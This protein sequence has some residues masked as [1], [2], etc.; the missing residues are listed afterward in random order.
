M[1]CTHTHTQTLIPLITIGSS[2]SE[3]AN[4]PDWQG[5]LLKWSGPDHLAKV[6]FNEPLRHNLFRTKLFLWLMIVTKYYVCVSGSVLWLLY[7]FVFVSTP[8]CRNGAGR[9]VYRFI[10]LSS[11]GSLVLSGMCFAVDHFY[12][13]FVTSTPFR[14]LAGSVYFYCWLLSS[15]PFRGLA[16]S[17]M[18]LDCWMWSSADRGVAG[19]IYIWRLLLFDLC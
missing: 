15:T 9:Q 1:V 8:V 10:V 2:L 13:W 18:F 19:D 17:V 11:S 3:T 5:R 6:V 4:C 7:C 12:C 16:D 14:G